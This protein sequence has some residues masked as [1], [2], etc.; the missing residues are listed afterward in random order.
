MKRLF[1]LFLGTLFVVFAVAEIR[2]P[3]E[4][5][6][7][8]GRFLNASKTGVAPVQ[9]HRCAMSSTAPAIPMQLAYTQVQADNTTPA[10]Y[11]FNNQ[12]DHSGF[13]IVSAD[14]KVRTILG[15]ADEG[16]FREDDMPANLRF[17]LGM[18]AREIAEAP[19]SVHT[20]TQ[21]DITYP[22]I[23]P[24]LRSVKWGQ[25]APYYNLC[26]TKDGEQCV[27]G[28]VATAAA[29]VMYYH[30]HPANGE[31]SHSYEWNGQNLSAN[32]AATTYNWDN[33]L[34]AYYSGKYTSVQATAVATLMSHVGIACDMDYSPDGSGAVTSRMMNA[35]F[36]Y[37]KYDVAIT[38]VMKD[39]TTESDMLTRMAADLQQNHP[40]VISG[41]TKN[42]EGHAFV[43]DGMQSDGL[44]HINWG[45]NGGSNG[46]FVIS[47]LDPD[48]Q[49]IGGAASQQGFTEGVTA[50]T[51]IQPNAGGTARPYITVDNIVMT[52][53]TRIKKADYIQFSMPHFENSGVIDAVGNVYYAFY[54][55]GVL[56]NKSSTETS[57]DLPK[58]YY[59]NDPVATY[60]NIGNNLQAGEYELV[61]SFV[62][63]GSTTPYPILSKYHKGE[64][65]FPMTVTKDSVFFEDAPA[66]PAEKTYTLQL[67]KQADCDMDLSD[68]LYLWWWDTN[69]GGQCIPTTNNG[70][71][72]YT[73]TIISTAN[74]INCLAVNKDV[75]NS[76]MWSSA[77]QTYNY[78]SI[79]GDMCLE[80]S[81][82]QAAT[83]KYFIN[84]A[85][86]ANAPKKAVPNME[87]NRINL[88]RYRN[89]NIE[90]RLVSDDDIVANTQTAQ[91]R[92]DLYSE[93]PY[94]IIGTYR[95]DANN[96]YT[97]GTMSKEWSRL[98]YNT[99]AYELSSGAATIWL[100]AAEN[101]KVAYAIEVSDG[102]TY[103]DTIGIAKENVTL[104]EDYSGL[105]IQIT[106]KSV[107]ALSVAEALEIAGTFAAGEKT[108]IPCM[109][110]GTVTN[111]KK[112]DTGQYG[113][114]EYY[115]TDRGTGNQLFVHRAKWL[116]NT[117]FTTGTEIAVNDEL[118][119]CAMLYNYQGTIL[120]MLYGFVYK[121]EPAVAS[122]TPTNLQVNVSNYVIG[123]FAWTVQ[124]GEVFQL[125]FRNKTTG[126][127]DGPMIEYTPSARYTFEEAGTYE[128]WVRTTTIKEREVSDWVQG[129]DFIIQQNPY[130]P[131][132]L[133]ATSTD[134]YNYTLTWQTQE[135][136]PQYYLVVKLDDD[137]YYSK[138][139]RTNR[140]EVTMEL[141]GKYAWCVEALS[142]QADFLART[143]AEDSIAVTNAPIY[144]INNLQIAKSDMTATI[145]WETDASKVHIQIY[146]VY[147]NWIETGLQT[148]KSYTFTAPEKAEYRVSLRPVNEGETHYIG[149]E[150]SETFTFVNLAPKYSPY[151]LH[152]STGTGTL[153]MSWNVAEGNRLRVLLN[154]AT[155]S[156]TTIAERSSV[157]LNVSGFA[158]MTL[159]W[160]VC[161]LDSEDN[162][163][164][165]Y[166]QGPDIL[167]QKNPYEPQNL[168][169]TTTDGYNYTFTWTAE[170]QSPIYLIYIEDANTGEQVWDSYTQQMSFYYTFAKSGIYNWTVYACDSDKNTQGF[171]NGTPIEVTDVP[172]FGIYDLSATVTD[173]T[174]MATW[175]GNAPRYY[176]AI[177]QG[178]DVITEEYIH[179]P[180]FTYTLPK[181]GKYD[182]FVASANVANQI[183][184]PVE[185]TAINI[186]RDIT[187]RAYITE[188][189]DMDISG[190]LYCYYWD[191]NNV[192]SV[193]TVS[194]GGRW[195]S[196]TISTTSE[197]IG[198]L[199][200]N[201]NTITAGWAGAQQTGDVQDIHGDT[202]MVIGASVT[203]DFGSTSWNIEGV[204]CDVYTP[205]SPYKPYDLQANVSVAG[206]DFTWKTNATDVEY[207]IRLQKVG[208][209]NYSTYYIDAPTI[210][211]I[212]SGTGD[213]NWSVRTLTKQ[214]NIPVSY[215]VSGT[216]FEVKENPY[217]PK[218]MQVTT[219]D[220]TTYYFTWEADA[221]APKYSLEIIDYAGNSYLHEL[222]DAQPAV[223][224]FEFGNNYGWRVFPRT[225]EG[226]AMGFAWG[227]NFRVKQKEYPILNLQVATNGNTATA[228][229][230][231]TAP[232]YKV[233]LQALNGDVK[234]DFIST[235]YH[236]MTN[237]ADGNYTIEITPITIGRNYYYPIGTSVSTNFTITSTPVTTQYTLSISAGMGGSV[238]TEVNGRY[239]A[240]TPVEIIATP[241]AGYIFSMWSDG[242]TLPKRTILLTENI[243][244]EALFE[245][246]VI[247]TVTIGT[248]DGGTT[249]IMAG[250]YTYNDGTSLTLYATP[251]ETHEF[252]YWLVNGVQ[253]T[254]NPLSLT[255]TQALT[256]TPVFKLKENPVKFYTLTLNASPAIGG[257]VTATPQLDKYVEGTEVV[258]TATPNSGYLF[259]QWSDGNKQATRTIVMDQDYDDLKATFTKTYTLTISAGVGGTV[260]EEVNGTYKSGEQVE[261]IATPNKGYIFDKWS[262]GERAAKRILDMYEDYE[263]KAL[264]QVITHSITIEQAEN[265]KASLEVGN[266]TYNYGEELTLTPIA[267][268]DYMF[269]YWMV[270]EQTVTDS[271]L[272][273]TIDKD[274]TIRPYFKP[275]TTTGLDNVTG[276]FIV[277]T[278]GRTIEVFA[279]S[280][281]RQIGL[282]DALGKQIGMVY[283]TDY[284][285]FSVPEAGLYIIRSADQT[286][287]I[288]IP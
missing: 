149:N 119:T 37:F 167:I 35:L 171:C 165:E 286:I 28:C 176:V 265:G 267:D 31:G 247:Y 197:Q 36:T 38:P 118:V 163:L 253:Q 73:A 65:R 122:Y 130:I 140:A 98:F 143:C 86:C 249:N 274:Y 215:F 179:T 60:H 102:G 41:R 266:H 126:T 227:P 229:W 136:A 225:E 23:A 129:A 5:A 62:Q 74:E 99:N 264:F 220:S 14:D 1:T 24:L 95:F 175:T 84:A 108:V 239:D 83:N 233:E 54:R 191:D 278:N 52:S 217:L 146:D 120:E 85:D 172:D 53:A 183:I 91:L 72:V 277:R 270:N 50:Y 100:D 196:A 110:R 92:L 212:F 87:F 134:G 13:V 240:G 242:N 222:V 192:N 213:Y 160:K 226:N 186:S 214:Y 51:G 44:V 39:H 131:H 188:D 111:I 206:V 29:Q 216:P 221:I 180:S 103:I 127:N 33:M 151:N 285:V 251:D 112:I 4:A 250:T 255:V 20:A 173:K 12:T 166:V 79:T 224:T 231:G 241:N 114:A 105:E 88:V 70:N 280:N 137:I 203:T 164:S 207:E 259:T 200:V 93:S 281:R 68:G 125:K 152:A 19:A 6:Q 187:L 113:N 234:T 30:K 260:N 208:D 66:P 159:S 219:Q 210:G 184:G 75:S 178:E 81:G 263:L 198:C 47:A 174:V 258:I 45:W 228:V 121:K 288:F 177:K 124:E 287:K 205:T 46:Y 243:T 245:A 145:T 194:D 115:I 42:D 56:V 168:Q 275:N 235:T 15:Y 18:Y 48:Q 25:G 117:K 58:G 238:N 139:L 64:A 237:L 128:W 236:Q 27:T 283:D 116:N 268:K 107:T 32:F 82:T 63:N 154:W 148:E 262:D 254:D 193:P 26:P 256:I 232:L 209:E 61:V 17:W 182:M 276:G 89:G 156:F 218:N 106:N 252:D 190:G 246:V 22:T 279:T 269:D 69:N 133:Q 104:I 135:P 123:D 201:R 101:Y 248:A 147:G 189:C 142:E 109:V 199:F 90:V 94:S 223:Y 144:T 2:T 40:I 21:A 9:A 141:N 157:T 211:I 244:L 76:D 282:V 158:N 49:G 257:T 55:N 284:A 11:V 43:C 96:T 261:I 80:I 204:S 132:N 16:M 97:S 202:C 230:D 169:A 155:G 8:A 34:P 273:L 138:V 78:T 3:G 10:L 7:I 57:I 77:Q 67:W 71:G 162:M 59:Y 185:S 170:T 150:V 181:E 271:L 153:T 272:T 195:W 161:T